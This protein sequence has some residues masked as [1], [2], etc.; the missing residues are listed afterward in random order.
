MTKEQLEKL[1][2]NVESVV[3]VDFDLCELSSVIYNIMNEDDIK[4]LN[5]LQIQLK[6]F[7]KLINSKTIKDFLNEI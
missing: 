2:I 4:D 5:L 1:G 7:K 3:K 6:Y